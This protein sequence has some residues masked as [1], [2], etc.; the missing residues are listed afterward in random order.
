MRWWRRTGSGDDDGQAAGADGRPLETERDRLAEA[1]RVA[2]RQAGCAEFGERHGG[3]VVEAP[4]DEDHDPLRVCCTD[5][6]DLD[7]H[8]EE[9]R[10][11]LVL[12][13]ARP[14]VP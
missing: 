3:F 4:G 12:A 8:T 5:D 11:Q 10:Y 13:E 6:P 1:I 2:L 9:Q 14:K 7:R